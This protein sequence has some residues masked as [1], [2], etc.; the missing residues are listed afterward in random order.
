[1][2]AHE[3][4]RALPK[5]ELHLHL[6]GAVPWA[7]VRAHGGDELAALPP[8]TADGFRFEDFTQF[9]AAVQ[10]CMG[11]LV[12]ARAYGAVAGA[13]FC[14]LLAQ[15][16]RY[17]ELSFDIVRALDRHLDVAAVVAAIKAAV[18]SGLSVRVFA[19]FSQ[20]K[21]ERTPPSVVETVLNAP[22]LDGIS[23]HGDETAQS[24]AYFADAFGDA[25]RRGLL[26]K[27]HAGE[28]LGPTSVAQALALL[29]V[30][31]IEH[32]VRAIEDEALIERLVAEAVTLDVC[33]WSNVRLG[34]VRDLATHPI[35]RLHERGVRITV[36]T[37]DPTVF[38]RT[39]TQELVSLVDDLGFAPREVIRLQANAF[40]VAAMSPAARAA[41]L[42]ELDALAREITSGRA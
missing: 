8:W 6:E 17:V 22:G 34:V 25:R 2:L 42:D 4:V 31:R 1:M 21:P 18:P 10:A 29:G 37:D 30:R 23:L 38:G 3:F 39:L 36:N 13:I 41:V 14:D 20:H 40:A 26:T 28:L 11:C 15:N 33:P 19:A 35:R 27:A 7:M 12:D 24:T 5:A 9:R 16:A 32:G